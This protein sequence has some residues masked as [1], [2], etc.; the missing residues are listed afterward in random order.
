MMR[1][2]ADAFFYLALLNPR[3]RAHGAACDWAKRRDLAFVTTEFVLLEVADALSAP[4]TR[5]TASALL[6]KLRSDEDTHVVVVSPDILEEALLL[7]EQRP[8]KAWSLTDCTSFVVMQQ[9]RLEDALTG[10][11]HFEQAGLR[12][13]MRA[14]IGQ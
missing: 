12:A 2:F 9:Q 4:S 11:Q 8:D 13:L 6:R 10:D 3:D 7:F 14:G 1:V 5:K